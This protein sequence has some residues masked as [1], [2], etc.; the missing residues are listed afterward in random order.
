MAIVKKDANQKNIYCA[1][2]KQKVE[3]EEASLGPIKNGIQ[4]YICEVHSKNNVEVVDGL[5]K[6]ASTEQHLY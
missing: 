5:L 6:I 2:C 4:F 3:L 1:I